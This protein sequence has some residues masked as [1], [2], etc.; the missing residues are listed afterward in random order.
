MSLPA[1]SRS[2][3]HGLDTAS[4]VSFL[5]YSSSATATP[6]CLVIL[7][8]E[9]QFSLSQAGAL[10]M[11]RNS[12]LALVLLT[13]AFLA[14]RWGKVR[15]LGFGGI[16]IGIGLLLYAL[17]PGYGVVALALGLAG[18]GGGLKEALI[19]PLIQD[20]H[21]KDS[22]RYLNL[23]N[24]FWSVGVLLTMLGG[25]ELLTQGVSWRLVIAGVGV[26]SLSSG[27]LFLWHLRRHPESVTTGAGHL[28]RIKASILRDRRFWA[29]WAMMFLAGGI[30]GAYTFWSAS[31]FQIE[32][33]T[34][35]RL[36]GIGTS[37]FAAGMIIGRLASGIWV[38]Q[39]QLFLLLVSSAVLGLI[40]GFL[41][42]LV[43]TVPLLCFLMGLMGLSLACFWPTIQSYAADRLPYD[44]TTLFILLSCGGIPGFACLSWFV[45]YIADAI[46]LRAAFLVLPVLFL[47]LIALFRLERR[48][49]N[50]A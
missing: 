44:T 38:R 43:P 15:C 39:H 2:R 20:L 49:I 21:P 23:L 8:R 18:L 35:P 36:G 32:F 9:L 26:L 34:S 28:L 14:G 50:K 48:P 11:I 27:G 5:S 24:A 41:L 13:S 1:A 37:F 19:N 30:E 45:G 6:I 25:G 16:L 46:D 17:A 3:W 12:T 47:P 33:A 42:P 7:A 4:A 22:G 29:F 31:Y 10:E 40:V